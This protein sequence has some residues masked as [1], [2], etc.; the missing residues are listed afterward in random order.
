M[1]TKQKRQRPS[2]RA[3]SKAA[4]PKAEAPSIRKPGFKRR[5]YE[6]FTGGGEATLEE[7][8][9]GAGPLKP[10]SVTTALSDLRSAKYGIGGTPLRIV[11][12]A[13]GEYRLE[14]K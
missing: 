10:S 12:G 3:K 5:L 14:A 1:T 4:A 7:L 6:F 13:D 8:G 9:A 11:K 2:K